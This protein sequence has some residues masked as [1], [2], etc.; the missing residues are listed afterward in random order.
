MSTALTPLPLVKIIG[1]RLANLIIPGTLQVHSLSPG[2]PI[3]GSHG[4]EGAGYICS[5]S[6]I[7]MTSFS[8]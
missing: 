4:R 5:T 6:G 1:P 3:P 8:I 7:I 2:R